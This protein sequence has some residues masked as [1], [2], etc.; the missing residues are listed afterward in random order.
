MISVMAFGPNL[1]FYRL[2]TA[3]TNNNVP[4]KVEKSLI[5]NTN[6]KEQI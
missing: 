1:M 4:T 2:T 3:T 6:R 5:L